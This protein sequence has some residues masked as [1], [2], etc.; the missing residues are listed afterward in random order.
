MACVCVCCVCV[1]ARASA[2]VLCVSARGHG[3]RIAPQRSTHCASKGKR[4]FCCVQPRSWARFECAKVNC[5]HFYVF[6]WQHGFRAC[7]FILVRVARVSAFK[8]NVAITRHCI[9]RALH[10]T[11]SC[12]PC[13]GRFNRY[14]NLGMKHNEAGWWYRWYSSASSKLM[15]IKKLHLVF[16]NH[17]FIGCVCLF[18]FAP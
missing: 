16:S 4:W 18:G 9:T 6:E 1:Y 10:G 5:H 8:Y 3:A 14:R 17:H 7:F 13:T 12:S 2:R 11:L 15:W